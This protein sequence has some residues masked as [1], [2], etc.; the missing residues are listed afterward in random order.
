MKSEVAQTVC[1]RMF[2]DL[3]EVREGGSVEC[4]ALRLNS[5]LKVLRAVDPDNQQ[6]TAELPA[7]L[8]I[9][10]EYAEFLYCSIAE[11]RLVVV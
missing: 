11:E 4:A 10:Q 9:A 2:L 6:A 7:V 8:G 1:G 5:L 3:L